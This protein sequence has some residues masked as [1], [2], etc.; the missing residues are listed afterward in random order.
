[1]T[2]ISFC[3]KCGTQLAESSVFCSKCGT[4]KIE[5]IQPKEEPKYQVT[6]YKLQITIGAIILVMG[7]ATSNIFSIF[8]GIS[9]FVIGFISLKTK[10][11]TI[12]QFVGYISL[13]LFAIA[14]INLANLFV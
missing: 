5:S 7:V 4:K 2:E 1:M 9:I 13:I 12:K 10:S 6:G 11:K 8:F 14:M 3:S